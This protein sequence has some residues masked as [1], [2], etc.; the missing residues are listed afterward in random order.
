MLDVERAFDVALSIGDY[1]ELVERKRLSVSLLLSV[2]AAG[3]NPRTTRRSRRWVCRWASPSR[4]STTATTSTRP[5][6][7]KP[8]GADHVLGL[9]GA[10]ALLAL[11]H[12][13]DGNLTPGP[14]R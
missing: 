8:S 7:T 11:Q 10:P 5:K 3:K 1:L 9:F 4:S 2:A 12:D 6:P 13:T 14:A